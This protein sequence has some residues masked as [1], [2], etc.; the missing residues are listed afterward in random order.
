[1]NEEVFLEPLFERAKTLSNPAKKM[2]NGMENGV[3]LEYYIKE[4]S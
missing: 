2:L 4:Y 3:P 1:M